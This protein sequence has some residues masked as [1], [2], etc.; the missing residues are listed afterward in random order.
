MNAAARN[1]EK[2]PAVSRPYELHERRQRRHGARHLQ[3]RAIEPGRRHREPLGLARLG[4]ERL[5]DSVPRETFRGQVR[6][7]FQIL[8]SAPRCPPHPLAQPDERIDDERR[9][10]HDDERE[11]PVVVEQQPREEDDRQRLAREVG[12]RLGD[13]VLDLADVVREA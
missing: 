7:V 6:D 11:R 13:H 5:H 2:S 3:V 8:L 1:A 10:R 12:H 4:A 9:G